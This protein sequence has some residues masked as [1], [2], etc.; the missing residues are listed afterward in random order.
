MQA[1]VTGDIGLLDSLMATPEELA[2]AGVPK[3][4]IDKVTAGADKRAEAVEALQKTLTGWTPKTVWNRFDGTFP[5]VIPADPAGGLEKDLVLYENA[6]IFAGAPGG[7]ASTAKVVVPPGSRDDQAGRD[8]EVRRAAPRRRPR[9]A[10]RRL[11]QRH[12]RGDLRHSAARAPSATR[13]WRRPSRPWPITTTPTPSSSRGDK[14]DVAQFHVG[15]IP[16]LNA[17][18]KVAKDA[19]DQL[20]YNKQIVDSLVAAYQTGSYPKAARCSTA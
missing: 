1:L 13:R 11:G 4:V 6:V 16:L 12:P 17:I 19:E 15:R 7:Q 14:K 18:V 5:H 8:L 3:E 10:G 2:G 20:S 9:E